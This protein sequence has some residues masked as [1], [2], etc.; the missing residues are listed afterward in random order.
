MIHGTPLERAMTAPGQEYRQSTEFLPKLKPQDSSKAPYNSHDSECTQLSPAW[1]S[2]GPFF[3]PLSWCR[4]ILGCQ[5]KCIPDYDL[6]MLG[7]CDR[8]LAIPYL[9]ERSTL[10]DAR[11]LCVNSYA[12]TRPQ[13][14]GLMCVERSLAHCLPCRLTRFQ[15]L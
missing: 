11:L 3:E 14:N 12:S 8:Q 9:S 7:Q 1:F 15:F 6:H 5:G 13:C 4:S 2:S 10:L